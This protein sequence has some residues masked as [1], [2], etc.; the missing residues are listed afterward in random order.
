LW[1]FVLV[2]GALACQSPVD[3]FNIDNEQSTVRKRYASSSNHDADILHLQADCVQL[4]ELDI[5]L[6]EQLQ[7]LA[8]P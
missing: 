6:M 7:H 4:L 2:I 8:T 3:K 5:W 1:D